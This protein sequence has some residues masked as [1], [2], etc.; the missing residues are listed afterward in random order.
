MK[1]NDL[2]AA[3]KSCLLASREALQVLGKKDIF[4]GKTDLSNAFR[5]LPLKIWCICWLV[6]SAQDPENLLLEIF[7]GQVPSFLG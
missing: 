5:V 7:R 4:L 1:Y 2:D 3:I 6:F